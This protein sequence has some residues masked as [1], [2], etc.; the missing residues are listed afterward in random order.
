MQMYFWLFDENGF[1]VRPMNFCEHINNLVNTEAVIHK[2]SR[3]ASARLLGCQEEGRG[4]SGYCMGSKVTIEDLD[5]VNRNARCRV[6]VIDHQSRNL[7]FARWR[8]S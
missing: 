4:R 5:C 8:W 1:H 3:N 6:W 2:E 7:I